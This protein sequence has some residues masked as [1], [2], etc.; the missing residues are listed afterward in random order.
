FKMDPERRWYIES[1]NYKLYLIKLSINKKILCHKVPNNNPDCYIR[2]FIS[3]EDILQKDINKAKQRIL[4]TKIK[5]SKVPMEKITKSGFIIFYLIM[6]VLLQGVGPILLFYYYWIHPSITSITV[7][8][9]LIIFF[10]A[11]LFYLLSNVNKIVFPKIYQGL[12]SKLK[13]IISPKSRKKS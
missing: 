1:G 12:L 11:F 5:N 2:I 10:E 7:T 9:L 4:L 8:T 3:M 6:I 13:K